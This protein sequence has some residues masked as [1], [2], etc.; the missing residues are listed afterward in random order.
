[1]SEAIDP[2][3]PLA[4]EFRRIA[5]S[6]I[7]KAVASLSGPDADPA[8]GPHEA[9]KSIKDMRALLRLVRGADKAFFQREN[10]RY[11]DIA[12]SLAGVRGAAALVETMDR[13]VADFPDEIEAGGGLSS[14]RARLI[15][16]RDRAVGGQGSFAAIATEATARLLA[17]REA[18]ADLSLPTRA[19]ESAMLLA[20]GTERTIRKAERMRRRAGNSGDPADFHELRKAVKHHWAHLRLLA[21]AWPK[22]GRRRVKAMKR[23][24]NRLGELHDI[25]VL[26]QLVQADGNSFGPA[27]EL[28]LLN[29]IMEAKEHALERKALKSA[30][31]QF[32]GEHKRLARKL[33]R[34]YLRLAKKAEPPK[35]AALWRPSGR[36]RY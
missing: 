18:L 33:K 29:A 1:M 26:N 27:G 30:K 23:L 34:S 17:A 12:Q 16:E 20:A 32:R 7:D 2:A 5:S 4:E 3:R 31:R 8:S 10:G 35:P 19:E 6:L 15:D 25:D 22:H 28:K 13:L 14:I 9:R 24:G 36:N 21:N 11:R